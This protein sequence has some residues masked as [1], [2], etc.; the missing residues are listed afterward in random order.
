VHEGQGGKGEG[1]S[2]LE[3]LGDDQEPALIRT[4]SDQATPGAE[5]QH[6]AELASHQRADGEAALGQMED[7]QREG[8]R[9]EPGADL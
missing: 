6:R 8:H 9:R 1:L 3:G 2:H 5:Q 7:E 4:I